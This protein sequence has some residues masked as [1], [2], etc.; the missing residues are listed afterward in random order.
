M[1]ER[2]P[3][4]MQDALAR[5]DE[6]LRTS[7]ESSGG[8]IFKTIGDAF[9]AAFTTARDALKATLAAQRALFVE[10]WNE[11][12]IVR[13]RMALHTGGPMEERDGDYFGQP[14]NRVARLLSAGHG[15]QVLLS[16]VTHDLVR[17]TLSAL[18]PGADL[19]DLGEHRLK[20]LK[21]S[22]RI[23]QLV[24]P[25]LPSEF[26]ALK[27]LDTRSNER[28]SLARLLGG[29]GMA[30][31][32]LAHDEELG[33]DVALKILRK[34]YTDDEK[35]VERFKREAKSAASLSHPNI[36]SVHDRGET[37]DGAYYIV[38]ECVSGGT[39]KERILKRG[40]LPAPEAVTL[41]LQVAR[42]LQAAH[43]RGVIHRDIKPQNILLTQSGE[44]KVADFGI[45]R[46]ASSS[47]MT[48]TGFV[49]GTAHYVSP[50]QAVGQP[51]SPQSDLYSLG[52]V[53]YEMLT[54][55]VPHD[56]ET[57]IGIAMK[58]VSGQFRPPREANPNVPEGIN[59][60]TMRLLARDPEKR[61]GSAAELIEDLELIGRR[62][63]PK[64]A[65][66]RI[67]KPAKG[68]PVGSEGSGGG[69]QPPRPSSGRR[70]GGQPWR[71]GVLPWA[72]FGLLGM[73][74]LGIG[75]F[76]AGWFSS[77][78]EEESSAAVSAGGGSSREESSTPGYVVARDD[79]GRLSVE[80]PDEWGDVDG[81]TWDFRGGKIGQSIIATTD[82]DTW[83]HHN[84]YHDSSEGIDETPGVL[85]GVSR[86][87]INQYPEDTE[88]QIL[89]LPEYDYTG[90]CEYEGRD[91]Y[92]DGIYTGRSDHW[93]NCGETNA[94]VYVHALLPDDRS[95]VAVIQVTAGSKADLEAQKHVL[96][97]F[98]ITDNP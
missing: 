26:P 63:P 95:Q 49:M 78:R 4:G 58:H 17:D 85:F 33:R 5:H 89:S 43:E 91:D 46:A 82:L 15:G 55:E 88:N 40:P 84:Y 52:V 56:A 12:T 68:T 61:Y 1:W 54:G 16:G 83:Y 28:Y 39:L 76:F 6:I 37:D 96:D 47:T 32:Y 74:L 69:A 29:G 98:K 22:E 50:E 62:Q 94:E 18:E 86:S 72:V 60:V 10:K 35:F 14:V 7:V 3:V 87:L 57:P 36:V 81:T 19:R 97:T 53:L 45:S 21:Y 44:A 38:M 11:N 73:V 8:Y 66:Q 9:C 93:T 71:R 77:E 64:S 20:D 80:V 92:D 79:S 24:I 34:Q 59:A 27:T 67:E 42:A 90:T 51:A 30:E 70:P 75:I 48:E 31:V 2:D 23:Y 65:T 41:T 13:V 25:D